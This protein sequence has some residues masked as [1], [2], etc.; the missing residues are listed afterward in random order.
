MCSFG[1]SNVVYRRP[2]SFSFLVSGDL[3]C[4]MIMLDSINFRDFPGVFV[5]WP[6]HGCSPMMGFVLMLPRA[7]GDLFWSS[8]CMSFISVC[9]THICTVSV[10]DN[11]SYVIHVYSVL[12]WV[13]SCDL[14]VLCLQLWEWCRTL[15]PGAV[16]TSSSCIKVQWF[17]LVIFILNIAKSHDFTFTLR[18]FPSVSQT[19]AHP[20]ECCHGVYCTCGKVAWTSAFSKKWM[21]NVDVSNL[22]TVCFHLLRWEL[23]G[24]CMPCG[25]KNWP[26]VQQPHVI[27]T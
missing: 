4:H 10:H 19:A 25:T 2:N 6:P 12:G 21:S 22:G 27:P 24:C 5:Q 18:S 7:F 20:A 13:C 1:N 14:T 11:P 26:L 23:F 15:S 9:T 17:L 16:L 8:N 3:V